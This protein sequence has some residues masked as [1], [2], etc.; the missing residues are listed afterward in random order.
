MK[1]ALLA[2]LFLILFTLP[3]VAGDVGRPF[4]VLLIDKDPRGAN[5]R[6]APAGDV[7][8][9]ILRRQG[10]ALRHVLVSGQSG[11]W[12]RVAVG[13]VTGWM[14]GSLLGTCAAGTEDGPSSLA[15]SPRNDS[16]VGAKIPSGAPVR[17]LG[18]H[19]RW[20]QVRYV[21]ANGAAH[22]GWL[23]EQGLAMS[24]GERKACARAW[25]GR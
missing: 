4:D 9:V 10:A 14:H 3:A 19:G 5:I 13:G 23:P 24:E 22:D 25:A 16:P 1:S 11:N 7:I 12:F 20:L 2:A 17:L 21:G 6:A 15:A 8:A 18:L